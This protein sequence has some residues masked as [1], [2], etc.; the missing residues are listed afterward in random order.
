MSAAVKADGILYPV[1][2]DNDYS[3]W[4]N[5]HNQYWPAHYLIDRQGNV[6]AVHFGEGAYAETEHNIRV[7]LGL[8]D[9]AVTTP[10]TDNTLRSFFSNQTPETYLGLE[11]AGNHQTVWNTTGAWVAQDQYIVSGQAGASIT[12]HFTAKKVY[13]VG[14]TEN[15][16]IQIN[17]SLDGKIISSFT[18]QA[19][20]L[21]PILNLPESRSGTLQLT[22]NQAGAELY[23]FTFGG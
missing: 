12:L 1:V 7:L 10:N 4:L 9:T 2:M 6:V 21:Y 13:L 5:Y 3:T 16:P 11:R 8:K 22:V 23:T 14:G 15:G 19:H 18:L 17:I 20:Q